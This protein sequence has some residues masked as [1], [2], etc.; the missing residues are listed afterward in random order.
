MI[1][2]DVCFIP[3]LYPYCPV[4][5]ENEIPPTRAASF[6]CTVCSDNFE[7]ELDLV[8][9]LS[10]HTHKVAQDG[11]ASKL[12]SINVVDLTE[13]ENISPI[14]KNVFPGSSFSMTGHQQSSSPPVAVQSS[15]LNM[16]S[17]TNNIAEKIATYYRKYVLLFMNCL[18]SRFGK[19]AGVSAWSCC[20]YFRTPSLPNLFH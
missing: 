12:A 3:S 19:T 8:I 1:G 11:I 10:L 5:A 17:Y 13:E 6:I 15:P 14:D 9:H 20:P 2:L 16:G 7:S 18:T 4:R